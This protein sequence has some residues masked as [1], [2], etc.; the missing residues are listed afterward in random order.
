[1]HKTLKGLVK[2]VQLFLPPDQAHNI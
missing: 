2:A 1:M